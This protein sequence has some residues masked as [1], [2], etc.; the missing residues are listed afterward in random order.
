MYCESP[1]VDDAWEPSEGHRDSGKGGVEDLAVLLSPPTGQGCS[2][3]GRPD[4]CHCVSD[5]HQRAL[6]IQLGLSVFT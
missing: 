2:Q 4:T 5:R 6:W 1:L 3:Q